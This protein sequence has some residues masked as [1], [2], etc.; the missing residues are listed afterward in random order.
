MSTSGALAAPPLLAASAYMIFGLWA[1]WRNARRVASL[2][3]QDQTSTRDPTPI[4]SRAIFGE[5]RPEQSDP[6]R[7]I[8]PS[9]LHGHRASFQ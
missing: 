4:R 2:S 9:G 7:M 8:G 5:S 3:L 6:K 1:A